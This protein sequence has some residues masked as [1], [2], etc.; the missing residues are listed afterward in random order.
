MGW[1]GGDTEDRSSIC[2]LVLHTMLILTTKH[3]DEYLDLGDFVDT[4]KIQFILRSV[5]HIVVPQY[6]Y[7]EARVLLVPMSHMVWKVDK[8]V[9]LQLDHSR[10]KLLPSHEPQFMNLNHFLKSLSKGSVAFQDTSGLRY[11][12]TMAFKHLKWPRVPLM[13]A[14][15]FY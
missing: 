11:K 5:I 1:A 7:N 8:Y 4:Y 13:H 2:S 9:E 3:L 12:Q 15:C 14:F 10:F 6:L